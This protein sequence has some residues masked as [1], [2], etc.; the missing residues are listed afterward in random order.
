MRARL[1][2]RADWS[3][4]PYNINSIGL[5]VSIR[6]WLTANQWLQFD[7][8]P[9]TL[10]TGVVTR[11]RGDGRRKHWVTRFRLSYSNSTDGQWHYYKDASHL[12]AKVAR[13]LAAGRP[14][15]TLCPGHDSYLY[16]TASS[17]HVCCIS[18]TAALQVAKDIAITTV[19]IV[20]VWALNSRKQ[21]RDCIDSWRK[22]R[23][24]WLDFPSLSVLSHISSP[25]IHVTTSLC[26]LSFD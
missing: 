1:A 6:V 23:T 11:G 21:D 18:K 5:H 15:C 7:I 2:K 20:G 9:P 25:Y 17:L 12:D 8:G 24:D 22:R 10:V 14:N 4:A 3:N 19:F 13:P 16:L 26:F